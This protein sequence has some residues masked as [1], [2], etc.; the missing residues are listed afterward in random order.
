M[1]SKYPKVSKHGTAGNRKHKTLMVLQVLGIIWGLET[2]KSQSFVSNGWPTIY[3]IKNEKHPI[4]S[5]LASRES[6]GFV[7]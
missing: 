1:A 4:I 3:D 5:L 7:M 2:D 6:V